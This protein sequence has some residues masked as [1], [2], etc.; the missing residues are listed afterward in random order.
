MLLFLGGRHAPVRVPRLATAS[1]VVV[2]S[3]TVSPDCTFL[4][5]SLLHR[6][7]GHGQL[8][9]HATPWNSTKTITWT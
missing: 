2:P 7:L 1:V 9:A 6:P 4:L 3:W 5:S 8:T